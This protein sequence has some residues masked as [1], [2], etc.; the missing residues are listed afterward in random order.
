MQFLYKKPCRQ[1]G[2]FSMIELVVAV[3]ILGIVTAIAVPRYNMYQKRARF[4]EV[5]LAATAYKLPAHYAMQRGAVNSID[6]LD[7]GQFGIPDNLGA[8]QSPSPY[9]QSVTLENGVITGTGTDAVDN[10][11]FRLTASVVEGS[12]IRWSQDKT[13]VDSCY[14][15]SLC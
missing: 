15:L 12:G 3:S 10:A 6:E 2:G 8:G 5:V 13:A 14:A 9:V 11:I 4:L 7:A 1:V